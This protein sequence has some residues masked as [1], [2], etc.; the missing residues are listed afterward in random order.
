MKIVEKYLWRSVVV[1]LGFIITSLFVLW[2]MFDV[3][4]KLGRLVEKDPPFH[5]L[6][7]YFLIQLPDLAQ[8]ILPVAVLFAT[9]YVLAYFSRHRES[10]ALLAA[11]M[12]P[13]VLAR[14]F[15]LCS[16]GL[17]VVLYLLSFSLSPTA[18]AGREK[19][20]KQIKQ[21]PMTENIFSQIVY[22]SPRSPETTQGTIWYIGQ[23]NLKEQT[24]QNVEILFRTEPDGHDL[25]KIFAASGTFHSGVWHLQGVR[26]AEYASGGNPENLGPLLDE[27]VLPELTEPPETL[28]AKL[29][30][31]DELPWPDVA[32]LAADRGRLNDRLRAP[33]ATEHWNRL[34]Y[35]L[36]CPLLCL[37]GI[38]FGMTDARRNVAATVFSSV[39]VLFGFLVWTRLSVALGQGNRIPA[40][41]AGTSSI[42]LFGAAGLYLFAE[43]VGWFWELQG[44]SS[45]HPKAAVWLRR[46]GLVR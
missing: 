19:V 2:L 24:V 46:V 22:R 37:F 45:Q 32:R 21:E 20:K 5:L 36:S 42:I 13:V 17:S 30:P 8:S 25:S 14:P 44:W 10:V 7:K 9:L 6:A 33:Y 1:P 12:S 16:A 18:Q 38:A 26:R 28:A 35:P 27:L 34:A 23:I 40:F 4:D 41:L 15:L 31:P 43:K 11:G 3:F 39:F 29:L